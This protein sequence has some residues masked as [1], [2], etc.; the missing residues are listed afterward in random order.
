MYV[1]K[2]KLSHIS[3]VCP[4]T[5]NENVCKRMSHREIETNIYIYMFIYIYI[6]IYIYIERDRD[7]KTERK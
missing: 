3:D 2:L 1:L 6:Y 7:R 5:G 4:T